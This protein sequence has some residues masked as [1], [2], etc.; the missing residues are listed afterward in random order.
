MKK[1]S[2]SK[3]APFG[4]TKQLTELG[5]TKEMAD[6]FYDRLN[7]RDNQSL[8]SKSNLEILE[9]FRNRKELVDE[10]KRIDKKFYPSKIVEWINAA[11]IKSATGRKYEWTD[12]RK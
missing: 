10:L 4:R 11:R 12:A 2:T 1:T 3:E 7:I 5:M 8:A 6:F 9:H